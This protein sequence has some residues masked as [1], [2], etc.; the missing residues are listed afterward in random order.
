MSKSLDELLREADE[1]A[2]PPPAQV[3]WRPGS[4][5]GSRKAVRRRTVAIVALPLMVGVVAALV[6]QTRRPH[7]STA[8]REIVDGNTVADAGG[9][10]VARGRTRRCGCRS[11]TRWGRSSSGGPASPGGAQQLLQNAAPIRSTPSSTA[12]PS[13][14][15]TT[16]IDCGAT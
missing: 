1:S 6:F 2:P 10:G 9:R 16:A 7:G 4:G 14:C 5:R 15:S 3:I 11:W 13:R 12:P 8:R